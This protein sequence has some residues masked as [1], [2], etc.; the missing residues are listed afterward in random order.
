MPAARESDLYLPVK[1]FLESQGYAVKAEIG[2]CDLL[3]VRAAGAPVVVELKLALNLDVVLQAVDRL[4]VSARV[5]VGVPR[6]CA[7]LRARRR[8]TQKLLRMLGLG[9]LA[10]DPRARAGGVRVLLDPGA[11]RPRVSSG[12][13]ERLLREFER[14]VG[15]PN[16]GGMPTRRGVMTA[17]RQTALAIGRLLLASGP[18][19]A[20]HVSRALQ[21]PR[22][23][24]IL[25][26]DAYGWFERTAPGVYAVSPRGR[27]EIPLWSSDAPAPA[28]PAPRS[29]PPP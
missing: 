4:A 11:Y 23:R 5:Y 15:D 13:Q 2:G 28:N 12:R 6:G 17:Y 21:E 8:Q 14:R 10:I 25:Y 29:A 1:R 16:L 3:A 18:T 20:S 26:R 9:L 22:A 19:K 7:A 27:R 24:A